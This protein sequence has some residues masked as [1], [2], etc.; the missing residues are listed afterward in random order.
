MSEKKQVS[1]LTATT[2]LHHLCKHVC[3]QELI[4]ADLVLQPERRLKECKEGEVEITQGACQCYA[5]AGSYHVWPLASSVVVTVQP[6]CIHP[7]KS[8]HQLWHMCGSDLTA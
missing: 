3:G 1:P 4:Q 5:A 8:R 6:K 2:H 7:I